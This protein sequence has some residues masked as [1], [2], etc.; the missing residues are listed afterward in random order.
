MEVFLK[1]TT[2]R[3]LRIFNAPSG[4]KVH[5]LEHRDQLD[6][7]THSTLLFTLSIVFISSLL[8]CNY[9]QKHKRV[10]TRV[11]IVILSPGVDPL[12][13]R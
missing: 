3:L 9:T 11:E 5:R 2:L 7:C 8:T 4:C 12:L 1:R 6:F 10:K 13:A